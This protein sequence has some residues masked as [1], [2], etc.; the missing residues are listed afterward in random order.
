MGSTAID[1]FKQIRK[2]RH[3]YAPSSAE[4]G[5]RRGH[6][7]PESVL[8]PAS[9]SLGRVSLRVVPSLLSE[10]SPILK[11]LKQK[12]KGLVMKEKHTEPGDV[13]RGAI[14]HWRVPLKQ[15]TLQRP[16]NVA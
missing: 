13:R 12:L 10:C 14:C 15:P 7:V 11:K 16:V 8:L 4:L 9:Q 2:L 3:R 1:H 5:F 6:L